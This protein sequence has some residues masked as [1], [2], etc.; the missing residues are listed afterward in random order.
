MIHWFWLLP[1]FFC[2]AMLGLLACALMV[3]ARDLDDI[4]DLIDQQSGCICEHEAVCSK[5]TDAA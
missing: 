1:T 5:R 4:E 2:G 3:A